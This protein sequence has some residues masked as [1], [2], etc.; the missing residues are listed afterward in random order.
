MHNGG[1]ETE[2]CYTEDDLRRWA[3]PIAELRRLGDVYVYFNNDYKGF[4]IENA[5]RLIELTGD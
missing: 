4:A 1:G 3:D 2:G 5:R